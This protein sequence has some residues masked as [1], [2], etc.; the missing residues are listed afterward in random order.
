MVDARAT[1]I[2]LVL[3]HL[4]KLAPTALLEVSLPNTPSGAPAPVQWSVRWCLLAGSFC[5]VLL[6]HSITCSIFWPA[7]VDA[8]A[9]LDSAGHLDIWGA[10]R[11]LDAPT[12]QTLQHDPSGVLWG[13]WLSCAML[14]G[15]LPVE[16]SKCPELAAEVLLRRWGV[17]VPQAD[18][19]FKLPA[20]YALVDDQVACTLQSSVRVAV[21]SVVALTAATAADTTVRLSGQC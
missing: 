1:G 8:V 2:K 3:S 6:D 14:S 9:A 4:A 17:P 19:S 18:G 10:E 13:Q 21:A 5:D 20:A 12:L 7:L 15:M 11:K 16:L